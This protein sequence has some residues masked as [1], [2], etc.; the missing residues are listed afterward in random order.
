MVPLVFFLLASLLAA[1]GFRRA[2]SFG[3]PRL[4]K[5]ENHVLFVSCIAKSAKKKEEKHKNN[6]GPIHFPFLHVSAFAE[7]VPKASRVYLF[8]VSP[9]VRFWV[10]FWRPLDF[11]GS[12]NLSFLKKKYLPKKD[13]KNIQLVDWFLLRKWEAWNC[14]QDVFALNLPQIKRFR[15]SGHLIENEDPNGI[16]KAQ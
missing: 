11:V 1:I 14:K 16:K 6:E 13:L 2:H 12:P 7:S 3:V 9:L 15:W 5:N 4:P 10:P 8:N